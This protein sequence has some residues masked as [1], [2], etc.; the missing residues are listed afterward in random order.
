MKKIRFLGLLFF[1][2]LALLITVK[3]ACAETINAPTSIT[4][5]TVWRNVYTYVVQTTTTVQPGVNLTVEPG[6]VIKLKT[7]SKMVVKGT[8]DA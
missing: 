4:A 1:S 5:D 2:C 8:L 7:N 3:T 6:T